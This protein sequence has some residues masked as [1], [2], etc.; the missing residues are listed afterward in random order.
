MRK[1][2][3]ENREEVL[4][5][6]LTRDTLYKLYIEQNTTSIG[7]D[8]IGESNED[9]KSSS[10]QSDI[11]HK[12]EKLLFLN[13]LM[14]P[15]LENQIERRKNVKYDYMTGLLLY[16]ASNRHFKYGFG[17][18]KD[19]IQLFDNILEDWCTFLNSVISDVRSLP[20]LTYAHPVSVG[21]GEMLIITLSEGIVTEVKIDMN[22]FDKLFSKKGKVY[23]FSILID[24]KIFESGKSDGCGA[25]SNLYKTFAQL[26]QLMEK[27]SVKRDL[28][29]SLTH[30]C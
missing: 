8:E 12:A 15:D 16:I 13:L 6:N 23:N 28:L 4:S 26:T 1:E 2:N 25:N 19:N 11:R 27:L 7:V 10:E 21:F 24:N 14:D 30:D 20:V 18:F 5:R 29:I 9:G 17:Y 3:K 22:S